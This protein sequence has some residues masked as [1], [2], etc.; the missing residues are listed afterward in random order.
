MS[1]FL[2]TFP[3]NNKKKNEV[4]ISKFQKHTKHIKFSNIIYL[5]EKCLNKYGKTNRYKVKQ[6]QQNK[7]F[8]LI[9][10]YFIQMSATNVILGEN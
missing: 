3:F 10:L 6:I 7:H 1:Y 2:K 8:N 9:L 5:K 4:V